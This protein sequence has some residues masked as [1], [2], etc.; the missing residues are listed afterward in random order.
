MKALVGL[1][2]ALTLVAGCGGTDK[3]TSS[4][5]RCEAMPAAAADFLESA[6]Y[7]KQLVG[8]VAVRSD[9]FEH[10]YFVAGRV[11]GEPALWAMN[12]LDGSG[13]IY[14]INQHAYDV[15]HM[16]F[17]D[18]TDA[19]LTEDDDGASEALDCVSA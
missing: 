19:H 8:P 7:G 12:Q 9:D 1:L 5:S 10:V 16:G 11:D 6:L 3:S 18:T 2:A 15:S 17:G 4:S 14:S 13:L